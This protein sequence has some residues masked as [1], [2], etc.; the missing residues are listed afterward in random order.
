MHGIMPVCKIGV[1]VEVGVTFVLSDSTI[2]VLRKERFLWR[3]REM[4]HA[5]N[6][7]GF[8]GKLRSPKKN[9]YF[10]RESAF[11]NRTSEMTRHISTLIHIY[12]FKWKIKYARCMA[13]RI[14][15]VWEVRGVHP[16]L[17]S[18]ITYSLCR[19]S[20]TFFFC[21][22]QS[23][24]KEILPSERISCIKNTSDTKTKTGRKKS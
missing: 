14:A 2:Q 9:L 20:F 13:L 22:P 11:E 7:I 24:T 18:Y 3:I 6:S 5:S 1:G 8:K 12:F 17:S 4:Q 19:F 10:G 21:P 15:R 16:G 23:E